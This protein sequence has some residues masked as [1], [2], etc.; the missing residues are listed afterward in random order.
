MMGTASVHSNLVIED[1]RIYR[2]DIPLRD[3]FTIATMSLSQAQNLLVELKTNQGISGWG[4]ASPFR[5]IA[6]ETQRINIAAA[7]ELKQIVVG[8][9]PL[10]INSLIQQMEA[11]LPHNTTLKSAIDMAVFDIAAKVCGVPLYVFLGGQKREIATDL[12]MGIGNPDEAGDKALSIRSMGFRMIKVKL[13]LNFADDYKRLK[14]IRQAV[15]AE[16]IIRIDANQGWDRIG[17][18]KSLNAFTEF[19]I[20]F[21]EQP[22]RAHDLQGMKYVSQHTTIPIMADESVFSTTDALNIIQQDAAPYF[23]IKLCKSGGIHSAEKLAHVAEAGS[24]PCMIGCMSESRLGI[25]AAAHFACAHSIVCFFDL[26]SC[27]EHADDPIL[28]GVQIKDGL[29]AIPDAPGI[30]AYPDPEYTRKLDEVK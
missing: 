30:G 18:T 23:N 3:V 11:Y 4:E 21:C 19:N 15:G 6:G 5:S 25:T 28:G 20:E 8:K 24:R 9:N 16:P 29:V 17:A 22:C 26:D 14:N 12:T 10:A 27:L 2:F 13:G 7:K 1:M